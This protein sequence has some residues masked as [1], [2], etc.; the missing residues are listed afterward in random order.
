MAAWIQPA[1]SCC[2]CKFGTRTVGR[3]YL[4]YIMAT[5]VIPAMIRIDKDTETGTMATIHVFPRKHH[6]DVMDP[7]DTILYRPSTS[8]QVSWLWFSR[9]GVSYFKILRTA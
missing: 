1:D 3:W 7:V 9:Y 5:K 2:G 6:N 4:E 8:N